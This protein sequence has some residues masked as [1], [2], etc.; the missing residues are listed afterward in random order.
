MAQ[1]N[2]SSRLHT[3]APG[4]LSPQR[5]I[6]LTGGIASGKSSVARLL[7]D[8]GLP[9]LDADQM[10]RQALA[11]GTAA[12]AAVLDRYGSKVASADQHNASEPELDRKALGRI[13]FADQ[14]ER[15]WLEELI[16][17]LVQ[18]QLLK[19]MQ[20]LATEPVLVLMIPLLFEAGLQ[21][22]C[23]EVWLIDCNQTVQLQRLIARDALSPAEASARI[24]SQWPMQRKRELADL[25]INNNG[26]LADLI[27]QVDGHS[28][29]TG[30][31]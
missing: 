18:A 5:R 20:H 24:S 22:L 15:H 25:V 14:N 30:I 31:S 19:E 10:A 12:T 23:T 16:H 13:V 1:L 4:L 6:G 2:D 28:R 9:V 17:P 8:K 11:P 3:M 21:T 29:S 26:T 7:I 27:S